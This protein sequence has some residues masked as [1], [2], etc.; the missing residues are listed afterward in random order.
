MKIAQAKLG[1]VEL[2]QPIY[3]E[4]EGGVEYG[5]IRVALAILKKNEELTE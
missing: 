3:N 1:G 4:L 5:K 2:I